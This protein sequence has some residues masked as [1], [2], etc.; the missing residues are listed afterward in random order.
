MVVRILP[1]IALAVLI[2]CSPALS[3]EKVQKKAA[4]AGSGC[5]AEMAGT[6]KAKSSDCGMQG[7][8]KTKSTSADCSAETKTMK[9]KGGSS[10]GC[11]E[12][13]TKTASAGSKK[14]ASTVTAVSPKDPR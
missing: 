2:A 13:A 4:K 1:G 8:T 14:A 9:A 6:T 5:C 12:Q 7:A 11:C 10:A 3:G